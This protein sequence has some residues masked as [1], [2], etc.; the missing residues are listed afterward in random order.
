MHVNMLTSLWTD[1][2]ILRRVRGVEQFERNISVH[3]IN[4]LILVCS[5]NKTLFYSRDFI[6]MNPHKWRHLLHLTRQRLSVRLICIIIQ[7]SQKLIELSNCD[8]PFYQ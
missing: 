5:R 6:V 1:I 4:H 2:L 8:T 7:W 3:N